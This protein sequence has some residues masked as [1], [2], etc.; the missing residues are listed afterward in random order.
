ML[1]L[2]ALLD[3]RPLLAGTGSV[4]YRRHCAVCH[5]E[6][7]RGDGPDASIFTPRPR[8]LRS[9]FLGRYPNDELVRLLRDGKPLAIELDPA[10]L[11]ARGRD[12]EAIVAHLR[13][14]PDVDWDLAERGEEIFVDR[15]ELCHGRFGEGASVL[16]PGVRQPRDLSDPAFQ[17]AHDDRAL[18]EAVRHGRAGMPAL[19][20]QQSPE[21]VRALVAYVRLLT[22]G[23]KVYERFCSSC[24][25]DD[26]RGDTAVDPGR[27]PRVVFDRRY[28]A[29][30]DPEAL[31]TKVWHMLADQR[32]VMPHFRPKLSEADARAIIEY[33]KSL[34]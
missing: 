26:G 22:P 13:R 20:Q 11:A 32:P 5:G 4:E 15:C 17:R 1:A 12:V 33:L 16:P 28:L 18:A 34:P 19:P 24:H 7:G 3:P 9:G 8:D 31:R 10:A 21:D 23:F 6:T 30:H 27:T 14:L 25:G 2:T 29:H